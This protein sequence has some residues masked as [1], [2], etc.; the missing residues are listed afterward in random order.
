MTEDGHWFSS[1]YFDLLNE[2]QYLSDFTAEFAIRGPMSKD[3]YV[4]ADTWTNYDRMA[5]RI[6]AAFHAWKHPAKK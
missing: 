3:L 5:S 1:D 4:V 2:G 6:D